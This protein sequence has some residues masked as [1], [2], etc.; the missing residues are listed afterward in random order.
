MSGPT[1]SDIR[2]QEGSRVLLT[3]PKPRENQ[4]LVGTVA[5]DDDRVLLRLENGSPDEHATIVLKERQ[6]DGVLRAFRGN[7]GE[8][9]VGRVKSAVEL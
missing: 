6:R 8:A 2:K 3:I 9:L 5:V 7:D 4:R 1:L